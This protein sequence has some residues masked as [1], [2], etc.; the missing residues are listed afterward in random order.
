MT[1][2]R[3]IFRSPV[4]EEVQGQVQQFSANT[5]LVV[6]YNEMIQLTR[7]VNGDKVIVAETLEDNT[8]S[9]QGE[10]S[11]LTEEPIST[12]ET[13]AE[14]QQEPEGHKSEMDKAS[15][16]HQSE[17]QSEEATT[18][19]QDDPKEASEVSELPDVPFAEDE[20]WSR[21]K[22]YVS[23]IGKSE[24]PDYEMVKAVKAKF[25]TYKSVVE[26]CNRI[27]GEAE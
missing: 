25:P 6:S 18:E 4:R 3:V 23:D 7:G 8:S 1:Q 12:P 20:H 21:V 15:Q 16:S 14:S 9:E 10:S 11:Q 2:Y 17:S 19:T 22:K 5:S 27:L 24:N 26:E 13:K